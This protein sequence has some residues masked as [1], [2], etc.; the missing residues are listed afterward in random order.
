M[1]MALHESFQS[2]YKAHHST[3]TALLT[4]TD[5]ILLSLDRGDNDN[6]F[7]LLLVLSAAFNT[8]N[9]SLLLSRLENSFGITGTVLQWFHSYLT[10]RSQFVEINDTKSSVRDLTVGV[11]QGSVLGP[12]LYLLYTA[13][14]AEIIRSHGLVYHFYAD[15]TQFYISFKDHVTSM[16]QGCA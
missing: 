7:P 10:G 1:A 9:H 15:N 16:L 2:A 12:I 3:E 11:P 5:D 13:L 4:I 8:V 6:V 14:L